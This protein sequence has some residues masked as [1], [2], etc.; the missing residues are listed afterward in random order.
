MDSPRAL[1]NG[2]ALAQSPLFVDMPHVEWRAGRPFAF[3][4]LSLDYARRLETLAHRFA[5]ALDDLEPKE[6]MLPWAG[7]YGARYAA[8]NVFLLDGA[9]L[10]MFLALR[11][12]YRTLLDAMGQE[13]R[14]RFVKAWLNIQQAGEQIGR[15]A[16]KASF[17]GVFAARAEGS[18][19]RFG[20]SQ[21][22]RDDDVT[23]PN[24]DGQLVVTYGHNHFHETSAWERADVARVSYAFDIVGEDGWKADRVQIPFDGDALQLSAAAGAS[25][26]S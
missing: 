8:Y 23:I 20:T 15:H 4:R 11:E 18:E 25:E 19:T 10:P 2:E 3:A 16:H 21:E 12:T 17:I 6:K 14:P 1:G 22:P 7:P 13:P 5:P 24:L 9:C 26:G